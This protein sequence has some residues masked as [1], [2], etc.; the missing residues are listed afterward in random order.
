LFIIESKINPNIISELQPSNRYFN[1]YS[2]YFVMIPAG[3]S[4]NNL[5]TANVYQV[6]YNSTL[7]STKTDYG[8]SMVGL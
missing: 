8:L 1:K 6:S 3:S 4:F 7:A 5:S 2:G